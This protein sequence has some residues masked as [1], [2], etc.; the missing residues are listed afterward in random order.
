MEYDST[1]RKKA[2][3][4]ESAIAVSTISS[5][6]FLADR[7]P[8][9]LHLSHCAEKITGRVLSMN[10][11]FQICRGPE[12]DL[13]WRRHET[14]SRCNRYMLRV[15]SKI[16]KKQNKTALESRTFTQQNGQTRDQSLK[17]ET[18]SPGHPDGLRSKHTCN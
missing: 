12:V 5:P 17:P 16:K 9:C 18:A 14:E 3:P 15:I 2:T 8:R 6:V 1:I 13:T 11:K 7:L 10:D 4:K